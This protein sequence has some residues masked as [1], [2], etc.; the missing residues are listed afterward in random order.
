VANC[1]LSVDI[2]STR[3]PDLRGCGQP[4][5]LS[6]RQ[7]LDDGLDVGGGDTDLHVPAL[8]QGRA[9]VLLVLLDVAE[10]AGLALRVVLLALA[11]EPDEAVDLVDGGA[12]AALLDHLARHRLG[13]GGGEVEERAEAAEGD[14]L[15]D[16]GAR[17]QVVLEHG[18]V[19]DRR[20]AAAGARGGIGSVVGI[21]GI[22]VVVVGR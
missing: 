1:T 14:V 10:A 4:G 22:V 19:E 7:V 16:L 9:G 2:R 12:E 13:G 3:P 17:E 18:A 11:L 15:V 20:R 6:L 21:V 8:G 5:G